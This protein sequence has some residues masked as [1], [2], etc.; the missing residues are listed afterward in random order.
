MMNYILLLRVTQWI[1]NFIIFFVLIAIN[2]I[3]TIFTIDSLYHF[4]SFSLMASSIY[5]INDINDK[6][7]D[8]K[9]NYKK[10][11]P[12][13]NGKISIKK[14]LVISIVLFI[15]SLY[16]NFFL[17][18]L[19]TFLLLIVYFFLALFYTLVIKKIIFLDI[20]VLTLFYVLRVIY[21]S[22]AFD[23]E[24][25]NF[26]I[27]FSFFFFLGLSS[28]KRIT[29]ID[30]HSLYSIDHQ[31][32]LKKIPLISLLIVIFLLIFYVFFLD[33]QLYYMNLKFLKL[34]LL[35]IVFWNFYLIFITLKNKIKIDP[36]EYCIKD[37]FSW[38]FFISTLLFY[39]L[40]I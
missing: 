32:L 13:A 22:F 21:G 23:I 6:T 37:K 39:A 30:K 2:K 9:N 25:S 4:F 29:N 17:K 18:N 11:R 40:S 36:I 8:L 31:S 1:K 19:D 26:L 15:L 16:L 20:I 35:T 38:I 10:K 34:S 12:I 14:A 3:Q 24:L 28:I 7:D 5:C 27:L 33:A